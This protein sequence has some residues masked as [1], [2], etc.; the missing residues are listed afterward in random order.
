MRVGLEVSAAVTV[1]DTGHRHQGK[2][3]YTTH[4]GNEYF[5]W[6][7]STE[8]KNR[9]NFLCLLRAGE[10]DWAITPEGLDYMQQ[11]GL[12]QEWIERLQSHPLKRFSDENAWKAHLAA[13]GLRGERH[14]R[15]AG[16]GAQIGCLLKNDLW[17][18]LVVVSDDACPER[19][20]RAG[21]VPSLG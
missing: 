1:D 2:N 16:E 20:R 19:R 14:V 21:L 9:L 18:R 7:A 12:P 5:A 11:Q 10:T 17:Q 8:H 13:L 4:I 3:G 6:F 15:I